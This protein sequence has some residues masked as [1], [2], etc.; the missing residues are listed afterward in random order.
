MAYKTVEVKSIFVILYKQEKGVIPQNNLTDY[1][2]HFG[3]PA[4]S[5]QVIGITIL[6]EIKNFSWV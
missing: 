2:A 3:I 4:C 1:I 6:K 5:R